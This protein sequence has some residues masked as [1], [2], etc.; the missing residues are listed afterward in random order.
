MFHYQAASI[1]RTV[2]LAFKAIGKLKREKAERESRRAKRTHSISSSE[3]TR[4]NSEVSTTS[5]IG[6]SSI[7]RRHPHIQKKHG[8][9]GSSGRRSPHGK[10]FNKS[11][12]SPSILRHPTSSHTS[13]R[14]VEFSA[15]SPVPS[16]G[17]DSDGKEA[18]SNQAKQAA[19]D[20][21]I[22]VIADVHMFPPSMKPELPIWVKRDEEP[23]ARRS[24]LPTVDHRAPVASPSTLAM[25]QP[26]KCHSMEEIRS[27][28]PSEPVTTDSSSLVISAP[29]EARENS[30]ERARKV[31][32]KESLGVL[33]KE[34][35]PRELDLGRSEKEDVTENFLMT[36][37]L[38]PIERFHK[39]TIV[40]PDRVSA[41]FGKYKGIQ[42]QDM[43]L[44]LS[45]SEGHEDPET[46]HN[47]ITAVER[48]KAE[49]VEKYLDDGLSVNAHDAVRRS[50]LYYSVSLGDVEMSQLL[51][52]R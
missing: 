2:A 27:Q 52:K 3:R 44:P 17:S 16:D 28:V 38:L 25:E 37:S 45:D 46:L 40:S 12:A 31:R 7:E 4:T 43:A 51:L 30:E 24:S 41:G 33:E 23:L 11:T 32:K 13:G 22:S 39:E 10:K 6:T 14:H 26:M 21:Q 48:G 15:L 50:L 49:L 19:V 8:V 36:T 47:A 20:G 5:T 18:A 35:I 1:V 9:E 29:R 34:K 42:P